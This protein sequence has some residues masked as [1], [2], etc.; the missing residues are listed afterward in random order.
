[1]KVK[2][3]AQGHTNTKHPASWSVPSI[4]ACL[5]TRS[6]QMSRS[7][8]A[9]ALWATIRLTK[10]PLLWPLHR[11]PLHTLCSSNYFATISG[12]DIKAQHRADGPFFHPGW[13]TLGSL[14]ITEMLMPTARKGSMTDGSKNT[15][16]ARSEAMSAAPP[17]ARQRQ[18][19][20][21]SACQAGHPANAPRQNLAFRK[22]KDSKQS[23]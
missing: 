21:L 3:L 9:S 7:G 2:W 13:H 12:G 6:T 22:E 1:M 15:T 11:W 8:P 17:P 23:W 19:M 14:C 20:C 5:K 18:E 16:A 10:V 4:Q